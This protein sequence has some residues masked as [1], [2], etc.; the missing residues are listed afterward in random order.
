VLQWQL[1][2]ALS[3]DNGTI[4]V[5]ENDYISV[6]RISTD[7]KTISVRVPGNSDTK[8]ASTTHFKHQPPS[9]PQDAAMGQP[10]GTPVLG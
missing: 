8:G 6:T 1:A 9:T 4:T 5:P 10:V 7:K 3:W 2:Q